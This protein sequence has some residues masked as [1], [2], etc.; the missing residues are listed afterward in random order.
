MAQPVLMAIHGSLIWN[1]SG[2]LYW[3]TLGRHPNERPVSVSTDLKSEFIKSGS[4]VT[5]ISWA[6]MV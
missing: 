5:Y 3:V 6:K 2:R 1:F 4:K